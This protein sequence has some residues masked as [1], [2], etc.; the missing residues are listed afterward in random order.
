MKSRD[1][2][3]QRRWLHGLRIHGRFMID[4]AYDD[5]PAASL[6][7][8]EALAYPDFN[9]THYPGST[10]KTFQTARDPVRPTFS[11]TK[12]ATA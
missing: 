9:L 12:P 10:F 5:S 3:S 11:M 1:A 7:R 4:Q 2:T 6:L 8:S